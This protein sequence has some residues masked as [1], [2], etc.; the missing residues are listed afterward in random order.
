MG[1]S[2]AVLYE[3]LEDDY[4]VYLKDQVVEFVEHLKQLDLIVGF[5]IKRFDYQVLRGYSD[6]NFRKLRTLDILEKISDVLGFRLSLDHLAQA[7][8]NVKKE[9]NGLQA[10]E[11]WKQGRIEEI[12]KYCKRDV[13]ITYDLYLFG[14]DN[15]YLLFIDKAGN[16][17]RI[18]VSW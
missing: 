15:G 10:L 3:V 18:P 12:V 9:G 4:F 13:K 8:L 7:T 1:V 17:V 14:K 16:A 6:V 11:W 5:N 2:C